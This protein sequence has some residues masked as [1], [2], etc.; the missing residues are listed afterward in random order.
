MVASGPPAS[1]PPTFHNDF[2]LRICQLPTLVTDRRITLFHFCIGNF[3]ADKDECS[4]GTYNCP[5]NATCENTVG[6]YNCSCPAHK[7]LIGDACLGENVTSQIIFLY[8]DM[9]QLPKLEQDVSFGLT[10]PAEITK[11][12]KHTETNNC[13]G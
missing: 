9:R 1:H 7:L 12:E 5:V 8:N 6:R 4:L 2:H 13:V 3:V 11:H 10:N